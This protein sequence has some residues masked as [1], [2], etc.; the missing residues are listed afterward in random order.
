MWRI[1]VW[2]DSITRGSGDNY[3]WGWANRLDLYFTN[4]YI[5]DKW[6]VYSLW[7]SGDT[8]EKLL[9]R[10]Q[11]ECQAR[12]P[13]AI[14]FAIGINDSAFINNDKTKPLVD[15]VKFEQNLNLLVQQAKECSQKIW[16]VG[17]TKCIESETMPFSWDTSICYDNENIK[18]Y[19]AIIKKVSNEN[20]LPYVWVFDIVEEGLLPDGLH[21]DSVWH[22]KIAHSVK[23][24]LFDNWFID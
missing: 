19:D 12:T 6:S 23:D 10:F 7:I 1:V 22:E 20:D 8:T 16:F 9:K 18:K 17:L 14:L 11:V 15:I 21:P 3:K 5:K 4:N 13:D 2:W 24:F